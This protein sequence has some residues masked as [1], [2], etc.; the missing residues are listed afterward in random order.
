MSPCYQKV[1]PKA[2][3]TEGQSGE[4]LI[5]FNYQGRRNAIFTH[6]YVLEKEKW[7][8]QKQQHHFRNGDAQ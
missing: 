3:Q 4:S 7:I 5:N 6:T 1:L 2:G 8:Q